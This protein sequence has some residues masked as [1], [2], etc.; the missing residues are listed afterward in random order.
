MLDGLSA[1]AVGWDIDDGGLCEEACEADF[2]VVAGDDSEFLGGEIDALAPEF[3]LDDGGLEG[4]G[5]E[6]AGGSGV[7]FEEFL[8]DGMDGF[9]VVAGL[10]GCLGGGIAFDGD[11]V[12]AFAG[13]LA[14]EAVSVGVE[15]PVLSVEVDE[16]G[17]LAVVFGE[18]F[19]GDFADFVEVGHDAVGGF[20]VA[21]ASH[22][23][24]GGDVLEELGEGLLGRDAEHDD[25]VG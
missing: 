9:G 22:D 20:G 7:E 10:C 5:D 1:E 8:D 17:V 13:G 4:I 16:G 14:D 18:V 23:P 12:D 3:G 25:A 11:G 2:V 6:D 19:E 24:D 15:G 21:V